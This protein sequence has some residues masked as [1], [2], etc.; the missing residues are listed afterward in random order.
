MNQLP[1]SYILE[2][3]YTYTGEP[4]YNKYTKVYNASCPVCRE[5]KSWLK[6]KRL[7]YY[8]NTNTFY[9]FN[10]EKSW[11]A[12]SWLYSVTGMTKEEI[13]SEV[14]SGNSSLDVTG[15]ISEKKLK[16]KQQGMLPHDSINLCDFQQK[17]FY[18]TNPFFQKALEYIEERK[19][20]TAINKNKNY[21]ISLTDF[22]HKN[23]LCI[24]YYNTENKVIFYQTRSL[25]GSEPR[26]LNKIG[27]EKSVFGIERI[28]QEL[29]Y[30]FIFEG[31]I[32]AM[33]VKNGVAV[34]GLTLTQTQEKQLS[35]FKFHKKIWVLDNLKVDNAAKE[36]TTKLMLNGEKVFRWPQEI[37]YKDFNE[38]AIKENKNEIDY[39]I[40]LDNLY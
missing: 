7:Y 20:N 21:Y 15:R 32:D 27:S 22:V 18:G 16:T 39:K 40:I 1:S 31:P 13:Q 19:L 14:I 38:W 26:Y 29:D 33:M 8:P 35:Q 3:F 24:P 5:G 30:I 36:N 17:I 25:D 4:S 2:K 37:F 28:D 11:T 23:R 12:Y 9:C 34:A 6:K 10:C